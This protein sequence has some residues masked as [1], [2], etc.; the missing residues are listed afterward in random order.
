VHRN[1]AAVADAARSLGLEIEI[2]EFPDGT[3][4]ATDAARAVGVEVAQIVKSLVFVAD[5]Q[6][7]VALV[8]GSNRLDPARLALAV[9][10]TRVQQADPDTV[11]TAT[12]FPIGGVPPLGHPSPLPCVIDRDLLAHHELWAAAGTPRHVFAVPSAVL[13]RVTGGIVADIAE[14]PAPG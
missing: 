3:R 12:G 5:G 7:V 10:A 8:A 11:K 2:R 1:A 9:G 4:T 13:E 6:P 14:A